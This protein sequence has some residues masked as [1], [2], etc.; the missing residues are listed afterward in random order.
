MFPKPPYTYMKAHDFI[1]L[2]T[3]ISIFVFV[4]FLRLVFFFEKKISKFMAG[5]ALR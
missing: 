3:V 5:K 1:K 2:I 4:I